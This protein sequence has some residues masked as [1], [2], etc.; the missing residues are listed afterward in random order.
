MLGYVKFFT[1]VYGPSGMMLKRLIWL[2][3][4]A[5]MMIG[6]VACGGGD[7]EESPAPAPPAAP[8]T[9]ASGFTVKMEGTTGKYKYSPASF[10]IS[11]GDSK[12]FKLVG[13]D[14]LHTFT[15]KGLGIDWDLGPGET[16]TFS[17]TF[18]QAGTYKVS[19][20][21]HP[22]MEGTITVQ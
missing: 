10:T 18:A 20:T 16:K 5:A 4:P 9:A 1:K 7:G 8:V 22:E 17:F 19:C 14:E 15:I 21:P 6:L 12:N 13:D 3:V 11:A 2:S